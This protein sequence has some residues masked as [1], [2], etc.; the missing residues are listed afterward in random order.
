MRARLDDL[1]S[2]L[3][4]ISRQDILAELNRRLGSFDGLVMRKNEIQG[5]S[6]QEQKMKILLSSQD[7]ESKQRKIEAEILHNKLTNFFERKKNNIEPK[8]YKFHSH[9]IK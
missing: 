4:K 6:K 7:L 8:T 9:K 3:D 5:S 2:S 1:R